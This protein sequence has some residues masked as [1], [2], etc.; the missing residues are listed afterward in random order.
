MVAMHAAN[1][2]R[3]EKQ[4]SELGENLQERVSAD[5][6]LINEN[7]VG[8]A[9]SVNEVAAQVKANQS[10]VD[11]KLSKLTVEVASS[12]NNFQTQST[13][14]QDNL[15]KQI[16][17]LMLEVKQEINR[18]ASAQASTDDSAKNHS[19]AAQSTIM[20]KGT[21]LASSTQFRNNVGKDADSSSV[22]DTQP[23]DVSAVVTLVQDLMEASNH[24]FGKL[25]ETLRMQNTSSSLEGGSFKAKLHKH[26]GEATDDAVD[27]WISLK[28]MYLENHKG[29]ESAK[30]LTL[31]TFLHSH[32]PA[33]MMQKTGRKRHM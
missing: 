1:E 12:F 3:W 17:S 15:F 30:V 7:M 33:W 13:S 11:K 29:N 32:A 27:A 21:R 28:K 8:L 2:K 5:V 25:V 24:K 20:S 14:L 31:L 6:K 22:G 19:N 10:K 23:S 9:D 16:R 18:N 4:L 26:G